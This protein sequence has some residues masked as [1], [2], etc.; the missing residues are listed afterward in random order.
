MEEDQNLKVGGTESFLV[1]PESLSVILESLKVP[2]KY[3]SAENVKS[4]RNVRSSY[5]FPKDE[6]IGIYRITLEKVE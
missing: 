5:A 6:R 2:E 1:G 3:V 4:A